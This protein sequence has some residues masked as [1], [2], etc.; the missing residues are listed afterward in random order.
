MFI[1]IKSA[2]KWL[3]LWGTL[4]HFLSFGKLFVGFINQNGYFMYRKVAVFIKY[5]VNFTAD[6]NIYS[7]LNLSTKENFMNFF[8]L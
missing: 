2:L 3:L 4:K 1:G 8:I 5:K 6:T 7:I